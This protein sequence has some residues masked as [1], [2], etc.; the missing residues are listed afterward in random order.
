MPNIPSNIQQATHSSNDTYTTTTIW[1]NWNDQQAYTCSASSSELVH[2]TISTD[3]G[4]AAWNDTYCNTQGQLIEA[5]HPA[6]VRVPSSNRQQRAERAEALLLENLDKEQAEQYRTSRTFKVH[7]KRWPDRVYT[8]RYGRA[9][10]VESREP[11]QKGVYFRYCIH[12]DAPCP[13]ED[14]MLAQKLMLET[15]EKLFLSL[16]NRTRVA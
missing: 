15:D 7:S 12:P 13:N 2:Y 9:G 11:H 6:P 16:A 8:V 14:V 1:A 10:N 5:Y 4:W 3:S